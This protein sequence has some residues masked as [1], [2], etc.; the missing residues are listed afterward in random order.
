MF[1]TGLLAGALN[2]KLNALVM[3][4]IPEDKLATVGGGIGTYFQLGMI[5]M[6]LA[7][8]ALILILP[9]G[10]ISLIVLI[11]ALLLLT[12]GVYEII[13]RKYENNN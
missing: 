12:Y 13:R 3:N 9:V 8:S 11:F 7:L 5:L 4:T 10:I 1:I 6:R 2:P